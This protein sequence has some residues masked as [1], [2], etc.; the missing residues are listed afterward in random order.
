MQRTRISLERE[1][2][3]LLVR[4][5]ARKSRSRRSSVWRAVMGKPWAAITIY[6]SMAA[7]SGDALRGRDAAAMQRL[8]IDTAV[9]IDDDFRSFSLAC[10]P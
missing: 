1:Q 9:A 8:G 6:S 7:N 2:Y 3:E 5:A 10:L 4:D